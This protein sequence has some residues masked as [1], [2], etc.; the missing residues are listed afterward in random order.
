MFG[1]MLSV[2]RNSRL[3]IS[4]RSIAG[5]ALSPVLCLTYKTILCSA[6]PAVF[7]AESLGVACPCAAGSNP[8]LGFA[9][10]GSCQAQGLHHQ[11]A[12]F[13][14][15]CQSSPGSLLQQQL[16]VPFIISTYHCCFGVARRSARPLLRPTA[17][18]PASRGAKPRARFGFL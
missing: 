9:H 17:P 11:L 18:S 3:S 4:S 14:R 7:S 10:G 1:L 13:F 2:L 8:Q 15:A 12:Q 5:P 16:L 6:K